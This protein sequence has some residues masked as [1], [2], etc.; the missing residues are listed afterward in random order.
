MLANVSLRCLVNVLLK[1]TEG[2]MR[3]GTQSM[4]PLEQGQPLHQ[5]KVLCFHSICIISQS[6][7]KIQASNYNVPDRMFK[8]CKRIFPCRAQ[9][10]TLRKAVILCPC[11]S[12]SL[13]RIPPG[14]GNASLAL[15]LLHYDF[16]LLLEVGV[17]WFYTC[18]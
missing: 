12:K 7:L 10:D 2:S 4:S 13:C 5:P 15:F 17:L 6:G 11:L 18:V 8:S 16:C 3:F 14:G 1:C 9:P